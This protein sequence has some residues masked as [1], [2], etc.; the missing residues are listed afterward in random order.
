MDAQETWWWAPQLVP[1][2][3]AKDESGTF[4]LE[5]KEDG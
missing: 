5:G 3:R 2:S 1:C 4:D